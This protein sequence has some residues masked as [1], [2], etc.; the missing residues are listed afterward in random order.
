[1]SAW[2]QFTNEIRRNARKGRAVAT[3]NSSGPLA[4]S[5]I[6]TLACGIA[7]GSL[8]RRGGVWGWAGSLDISGTALR[9]RCL[10]WRC[11]SC[12]P[13]ITCICPVLCKIRTP[14]SRSALPRAKPPRRRRHRLQLTTI[15]IARS[16]PRYSWH[17][18][19]SR[20]R[21]RNC[22]CRRISRG[23]S[24]RSM[25]TLCSRNGRAWRFGRAPHPWPKATVLLT[26]LVA[27]VRFFAPDNSS[28]Q[29]GA[30]S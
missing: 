4:K 12:S 20:R 23:S 1:M 18:R 7:R 6:V 5:N 2:R 16:A 27:G 30:L 3:G 26:F 13:S 24:I 22:R 21:R 15:D 9:W 28:K 11:K 17:R 8:W 25:R 29:P 14:R 10:R 19:R